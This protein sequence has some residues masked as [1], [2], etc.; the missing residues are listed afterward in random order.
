MRVRRPQ[1]Q[2]VTLP[3]PDAEMSLANA[4]KLALAGLGLATFGCAFTSLK[5]LPQGLLVGLPLIALVFEVWGGNQAKPFAFLLTSC[6]TAVS[7]YLLAGTA[8]VTLAGQKLFP[9]K[10]ESMPIGTSLIGAVIGLLLFAITYFL[11]LRSSAKDER[12]RR[13]GLI[14]ILVTALISRALDGRV[15]A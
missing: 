13:A 11:L 6:V 15:L 4:G 3:L 2:P 7:G 1:W 10:E 14:A 9:V 5:P 12:T 8:M